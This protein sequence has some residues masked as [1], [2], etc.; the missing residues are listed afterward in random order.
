VVLREHSTVDRLLQARAD[1]IGADFIGY[2]HHVYR[3]VNLCMT[4][5]S[6]ERDGERLEKI[7]IAAAFH[8]MGIWTDRTFDYLDPSIALATAHLARSGRTPW[9]TE[10]AAMIS[11]H[12]RVRPCR[13]GEHPLV[14]PFRRADWIDVSRG[15]IRFGVPASL[16]RELFSIWPSAGFH[17]RLVQLTLHRWRSHPLSPLPMLRL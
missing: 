15:W 12:H 5:A 1:V 2:R 7:A 16:V 11:E 10:I 3:V 8:D 9:T 6:A 4:L 14:E 13:S 17:A